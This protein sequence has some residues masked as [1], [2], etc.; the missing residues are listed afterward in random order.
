VLAA[1]NP[2][3]GSAG[4]RFMAW[5]NPIHSGYAFGDGGRLLV[6]LTGLAAVLFVA[7]GVPLWYARRRVRTRR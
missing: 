1:W 2:R 3:S 7:T 5:L 4:D 6:F